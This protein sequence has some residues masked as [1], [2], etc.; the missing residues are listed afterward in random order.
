MSAFFS[1]EVYIAFRTG[2]QCDL[3]KACVLIIK[4]ENEIS[5]LDIDSRHG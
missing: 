3:I 2:A 5:I 4:N 1:S